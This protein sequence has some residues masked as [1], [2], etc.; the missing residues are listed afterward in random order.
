MRPDPVNNKPKFPLQLQSQK[1]VRLVHRFMAIALKNKTGETNE[2]TAEAG[3]RNADG[4]LG[5]PAT[6]QSGHVSH[7]R[8][9]SS[10]AIVGPWLLS[11]TKRLPCTSI[12]CSKAGGIK[13]GRGKRDQRVN[14]ALAI[15]A[16]KPRS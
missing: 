10:Q 14:A 9:M 4:P 1:V 3:R 6:G 15:S 13:G 11:R 12:S 16:R 8:R 7:F 2:H 5:I